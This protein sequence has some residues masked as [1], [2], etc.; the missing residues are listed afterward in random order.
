MGSRG[1][2]RPHQLP[3]SPHLDTSKPPCPAL[4]CLAQ[5]LGS[6]TDGRL[7]ELDQH[8]GASRTLM[9]LFWMR[10]IRLLA[11]PSKSSAAASSLPNMS[12]TW[13]CMYMT[14]WPTCDGESSPNLASKSS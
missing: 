12:G 5:R 7:R 9:R 10:L 3:A 4:P 6:G 1:S 2:S 14:P 11:P 8:H 13:T